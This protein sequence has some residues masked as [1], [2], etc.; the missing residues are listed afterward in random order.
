MLDRISNAIAR[1][2]FSIRK[3]RVVMDHPPYPYP[4]RKRRWLAVSDFT[5][6]LIL[7]SRLKQNS[8]AERIAIVGPAV[9]NL[10]TMSF[11]K[12]PV[13]TENKLAAAASTKKCD[14]LLVNWREV[15]A[16]T[17]INA[18]ARSAPIKRSPTRT[19][20]LKRRRK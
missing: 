5:S 8:R 20:R 7:T 10:K 9:E 1:E 14:N 2:G 12:N 16:G 6:H 3:F 11:N 15:A 18:L 4:R 19:V 13:V 17:M